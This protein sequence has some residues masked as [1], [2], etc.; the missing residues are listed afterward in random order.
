MTAIHWKSGISGF[1]DNA[2]NWSTGTVPGSWDDALID[3]SG[4][5]TVDSLPLTLTL[6]SLTLA[7]GATLEV[8]NAELDSSCTNNGTI[9]VY[10]QLTLFGTLNNTGIMRFSGAPLPTVPPHELAYFQPVGTNSNSGTLEAINDAE[11]FFNISSAAGPVSFTNYGTL[12][13]EYGSNITIGGN[14]GST[15]SFTNIGIIEA[16][17]QGSFVDLFSTSGTISNLGHLVADGGMIELNNPN[18]I[19]GTGTAEIKNG[20]TLSVGF[21]TSFAEDTIFDP[22]AN[23]TLELRF[24]AAFTG[25]L[26]GFTSGDRIDFSDL[27]YSGSTLSFDSLNSALTV[28]SG[29]YSTTI[30]LSGSY[31]GSG[32]NLSA[33]AS[34]SAQV[35]YTPTAP[36]NHSPAIDATH[37]VVARTIS[38]RPNVTGS[39]ALDIANGAIAFTDAD[40]NDRP[41]ASVTHQTVTW[42]DSHGDVFQLTD[43]QIF[44][45]ENA[46]LL[47]PESGNTNNGK[48][49]WGFTAQDSAFDFLGV[50][51]TLTVTKS[52]EIDDGHGGKVDQ[53]VTVTIN[54]ADDL[55][56]AV[57]DTATVQK[58]DL[59]SGN[60]LTNDSDP[61][62]HDTHD[63][64][65]IT[66]VTIDGH[67]YGVGQ[68]AIGTYGTLIWG[69]DGTFTY[70][71]NQSLGSAT[72]TGAID[73]FT[74][75]VNGGHVGDDATTSLTINISPAQTSSPQHPPLANSL[76]DLI[77]EAKLEIKNQENTP[78]FLSP[79]HLTSNPTLVDQIA[80]AMANQFGTPQ[81]L[82]TIGST[83][84]DVTDGFI[85]VTSELHVSKDYAFLDQCV[86]LVQALDKNVGGSTTWR[87][88]TQVDV[89]GQ[90]ANL[91]AGSPIATFTN[92]KY[93]GEHAAIFLGSGVENG[94]AGVFVLDQY[95]LP[96]SNTGPTL[97]PDGTALNVFDYEP[98]EVRFIDISGASTSHYFLI[99]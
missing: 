37:S 3:A 26:S 24:G 76:T 22:G 60:V 72:K 49:D 41:T 18:P 1:F 83:K 99:A 92:G 73:T 20:G 8:W 46:L 59:V 11:V 25:V 35:S 4:T 66:K 27:P 57:R 68:S 16:V 51:E 86:A 89:N 87:P 5:Y 36:T 32:F 64:L 45:F 91:A 48:I 98:A 55:P 70:F 74:Y 13:A 50:G 7:V 62:L 69:A 10:S 34:G 42:Q 21:E 94:V 82:Y 97:Y 80:V 39:L 84:G 38:E 71:A 47:V 15:S 40:L 14:F 79:L 81:S 95:N 63:K 65:H 96:A 30:H 23:G 75:T 29:V 78:D 17:G 31:V 52:V 12:D 58:G 28:S 53:D 6:Q 90:I 2:S 77:D 88:S 93:D 56:I 33:D 9:D 61:D 43:A 67:E 19:S 54:G 44:A 85:N